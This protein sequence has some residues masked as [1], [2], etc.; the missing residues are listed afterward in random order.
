MCKDNFNV[1]PKNQLFVQF[2]SVDLCTKYC[3]RF[4]EENWIL[5]VKAVLIS[6]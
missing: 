6:I 1:F 4:F 3:D 2:R 5:K